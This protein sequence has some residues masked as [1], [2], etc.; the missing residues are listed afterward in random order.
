M[1]EK[2]YNHLGFPYYGDAVSINHVIERTWA[3]HLHYDHGYTVVDIAEAM[4]MLP[5]QVR[6]LLDDG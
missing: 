6:E 3:R 1:D 2:P 5:G 4:G